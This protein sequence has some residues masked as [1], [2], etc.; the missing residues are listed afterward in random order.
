MERYK[1]KTLK[2]KR[3]GCQGGRLEK[4]TGGP[5]KKT[6]SWPKTGEGRKGGRQWG[7]LKKDRT[8]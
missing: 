6:K 7:T 8:W 2:T 4:Q 1:G 3:G 5:V